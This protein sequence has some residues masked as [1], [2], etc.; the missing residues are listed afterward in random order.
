MGMEAINFLFRSREPLRKIIEDKSG[1]IY[2]KDEKYVFH[3]VNKFWIDIELQDIFSLSIRMTLSN[4]KESALSALD[5]LLLYLFSFENGSLINLDS[6]EV[7]EKYNAEVKER[8]VNSYESRKKVFEQ[9]YG[10]FTAA[11]SSEE[12]YKIRRR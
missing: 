5:E 7:F 11:V 9:M 6:K 12:F 8:I 10:D 1:I 2:L 4:P 3:V